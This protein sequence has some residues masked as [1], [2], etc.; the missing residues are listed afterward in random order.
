MFV[1]LMERALRAAAGVS[2]GGGG[3]A[4]LGLGASS[5]GAGLMLGMSVWETTLQ[6]Q[7]RPSRSRVAS[8]D[9]F[10]S[11]AFY[12]LGPAPWGD[13]AGAIGCTPRS[14]W[15]SACCASAACCWWPCPTS[16]VPRVGALDARAQIRA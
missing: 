14:G 11:Y 15:R 6:R 7:S 2:R 10:G 16:G 12:P 8:Y 3:A 1:A 4:V 13:A 9:W 5:P